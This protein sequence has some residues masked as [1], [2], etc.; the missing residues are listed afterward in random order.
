MRILGISGSPRRGGNTDF[1]V[2]RALE[3]LGGDGNCGGG[4]AE[5]LRIHDHDIRHCTGCRA[6]TK[7]GRCVIRGDD[8]QR[9]FAQVRR[10]DVLVIGAPVYWFAP[11]GALKDF[12]D[13]THGAYFDPAKPLAGKRAALITVA[14][15]S[16]WATHERVL[17]AWLTCYGAEVVGKVRLLA[18]EMGELE[19]SPSELRKLDALVRRV[20][21]RLGADV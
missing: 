11:P 1:A 13:R 16:G 19:A 7:A 17:T 18:K 8:F 5:F 6:C 12:I 20:G 10:A 15:D 21:A 4:R 14:A 3:R 2:R 9:L